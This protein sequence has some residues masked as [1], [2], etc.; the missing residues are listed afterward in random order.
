MKSMTENRATETPVH[1]VICTPHSVRPAS[2]GALIQQMKA[3]DEPGFRH[4][5]YF[6]DIPSDDEARTLVVLSVF[7]TDELMGALQFLANVENR[8]QS[9]AMKVMVISRATHPKLST[10]LKLKGV[11]EVA[12]FQ[13]SAKTLHYKIRLGVEQLRKASIESTVSWSPE[14]E[15]ASDFW[16]TVNPKHVRFVI[17][18]WF[19]NLYGPGPS[20]GLWQDSGLRLNG[21]KGWIF[22]P[23]G[24]ERVFFKGDGRWIFF[25]NCPEFSW[26]LGLW[27]FISKKPFFA[28]Y[29]KNQ[30]VYEKAWFPNDGTFAVRKNSLQAKSMHPLIQATIE[31]SI[32]LKHERST[33]TDLAVSE[34][35]Q[36][37]EVYEKAK[38]HFTITEKNGVSTRFDDCLELVLLRGNQ[39]ILNVD[40]GILASGDRISLEA[41]LH[42]GDEQSK[43]VF[44]ATTRVIA[45]EE[46][47]PRSGQRIAAICELDQTV[48]G[49]FVGL[50]R[51]FRERRERMLEFFTNARGA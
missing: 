3:S 38:I 6:S 7:E 39:A 25:G 20:A 10:L 16:S 27:Y 45:T 31:A 17:G 30:V 24:E 36:A 13:L 26:S 40:P 29:E 21:E 18:K 49:H 22:Q 33:G 4:V 50:V 28:F 41:R 15:H 5:Q 9:G 14:V 35:H 19:M 23:R 42:E 11:F 2:L 34:I 44:T 46:G 32:L 47:E 12:D 37:K 51:I 43:I 8:I 48:E 1:L